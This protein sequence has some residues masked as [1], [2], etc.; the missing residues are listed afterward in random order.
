MAKYHIVAKHEYQKL[1][2]KRSFLFSTLGFP[3]LIAVVITVSLLTTLGKKGDLPVGYV[4]NAGI[5]K[6]TTTLYSSEHEESVLFIAIPSKATAMAQLRA[7]EVQAVYLLSPDYPRTGKVELYYLNQRPSV[8]VQEDF[9]T[10]LKTHLIS[11]QPK[12]IQIR[13]MEG[14]NIIIQSIDSSRIFDSRNIINFFIPFIAAFLFIIAVMSAGGYMLAAVTEEK[15]NRTIEIL[16]T[17]LRP[18]ELIGGKALGLMGVGLTQLSLWA[19]TAIVGLFILSRF[20]DQ[21]RLIKIPWST[22]GIV[23]LFFLPAYALMSGM[24]IIIGS[25]VSDSKQ[26]QQISGIINMLFT[27]PFFFITLIIAK[28]N[29]P[30]SIV[31]SLFPTTA[32]ITI[33]M[34]WAVSTIPTWQLISSLIILT[35]SSLLSVWIA[36]RVFRFGMLQYGQNFKVKHIVNAFRSR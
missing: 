6:E 13:L 31:L 28:P 17:S 3:L 29:N 20:Y 7:T 4:D 2:N 32:F 11:N 25:M 8:S 9:E 18:E 15:E 22:L 10:F 12:E 24:M 1:V 19:I 33:T 34:R 30:I 27:S 36:T 5:L 14:T 35:C 16:T 21:L 26:G 23:C